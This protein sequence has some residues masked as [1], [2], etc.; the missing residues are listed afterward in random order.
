M[1]TSD[2]GGTNNSY[3]LGY[4]GYGA[5]RKIRL[6]DLFALLL[7]SL[8]KS[9]QSHCSIMSLKDN[10]CIENLAVPFILIKKKKNSKMVA[11]R[12][13]LNYNYFACKHPG[14]AIRL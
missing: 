2:S 4:S 11:L 14:G 9:A 12:Q 13:M 10:P 8:H 5:C 3:V 6:V 1:Q 7:F